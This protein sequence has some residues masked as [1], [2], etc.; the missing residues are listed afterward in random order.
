MDRLA[1]FDVDYTLTRR[2]TQVE[3]LKFLIATDFKNITHLP[4][5]LAAGL[6]FILGLHDE[7]KS[8][9]QNLKMLRGITEDQ[10]DQL[11]RTFMLRGIRPILYQ[12]GIRVL[13]RHH[14]EGMRVILNSASPEF[15]IREFERSPYVEKAI[16]TR[17]EVLD[18]IF[19]GKMIG[20][21]NKGDEKI[22]RL[23]E[24]LDG[25]VIDWENS[26]MYSD[27]LSDKPLMDK[28]GKAWL[29]NH[30]ANPHFPVM[31]WK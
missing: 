3:L 27:S 11:G 2:E 25:D 7:K 16:G 8:K 5:S 24:Y 4:N 26:I 28:M 22:N 6:G 14:C 30:K 19:T 15:Y 29:I 9:E 21:N 18:G 20:R 1:V 31:R 17:F 23:M 13:K 12:D 10:L